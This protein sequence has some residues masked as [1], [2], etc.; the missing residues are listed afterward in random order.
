MSNHISKTDPS[1]APKTISQDTVIEIS[2]NDQA[3]RTTLTGMKNE[4]HTQVYSRTLGR[5]VE[6]GVGIHGTSTK[7]NDYGGLVPKNPFASKLQSAFAHSSENK[8]KFGGD[9]GLK[10]WDKS[11]NYAAL[12]KR[13]K[14]K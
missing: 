1:A 9:A 5:M 8:S 3:V 14:E 7:G 10:E 6:I 11:T 2:N 12:P 13:A 4:E